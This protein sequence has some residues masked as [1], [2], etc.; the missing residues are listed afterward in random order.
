MADQESSF[1]VTHD[2][3]HGLRVGIE[4]SL[5]VQPADGLGPNLHPCN[6]G[7]VVHHMDV[8]IG[9]DANHTSTP[10]WSKP[11][12][13]PVLY[14]DEYGFHTGNILWRGRFNGKSSGVS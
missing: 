11:A 12:T 7:V 10:L 5:V 2:H 9:L 4:H 13:Y 6:I 3:D 14:A 8:V 1:T